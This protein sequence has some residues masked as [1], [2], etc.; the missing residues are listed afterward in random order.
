MNHRH[1]HRHRHRGGLQ[2]YRQLSTEQNKGSDRARDT[3]WLL[4]LSP[5]STA[6][7]GVPSCRQRLLLLLRLERGGRRS[8][9]EVLA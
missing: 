7:I 3:L 2:I 4:Q 5:T 1:R 6:Q 8:S 9:R